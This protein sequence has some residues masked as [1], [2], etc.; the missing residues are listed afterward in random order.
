MC[1]KN[2]TKTRD[3]QCT[4]QVIVHVQHSVKST[5]EENHLVLVGGV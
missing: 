1:S 4:I 3:D 5:K 2:Q